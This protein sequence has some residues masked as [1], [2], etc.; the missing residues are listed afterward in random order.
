M[1]LGFFLRGARRHAAP[2]GR[3]TSRAAHARL[4]AGLA[5]AQA[6]TP[7]ARAAARIPR[8]DPAQPGPVDPLVTLLAGERDW[9][10]APDALGGSFHP[11]A[12]RKLGTDQT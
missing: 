4:I 3:L 1:D 11:A 7:T 9:E 10:A 5:A 2:V 6:A 12:A 8:P